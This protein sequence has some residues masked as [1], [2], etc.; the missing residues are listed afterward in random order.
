VP[1]AGEKI[2]FVAEDVAKDLGWLLCENHHDLM[3]G[4]GGVHD[5]LLACRA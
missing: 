4:L 5:R 1:D 3:M 2:W